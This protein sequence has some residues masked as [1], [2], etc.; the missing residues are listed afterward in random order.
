[1]VA[2]SLEVCKLHILHVF[3]IHYMRAACPV[4]FMLLDLI[5][6]KNINYQAPRFVII[7]DTVRPLS[8][9]QIFSS[10]LCFQT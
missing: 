7:F 5:T 4:N 10:T 8:W 9:V 2:P 3:R 1:V 6:L